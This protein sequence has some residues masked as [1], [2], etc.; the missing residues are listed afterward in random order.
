MNL[1]PSSFI[2]TSSTGMDEDERNVAQTMVGPLLT[3]PPTTHIVVDNKTSIAQ[4]IVV[5][6]KSWCLDRKFMK[7]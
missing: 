4:G 3:Q 2:I 5:I 1:F 6:L 7:R